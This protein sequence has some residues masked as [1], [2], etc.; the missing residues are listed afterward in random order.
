MRPLS[1]IE[2]EIEQGVAA[3]DA[4]ESARHLLSLGEE[5][6]EHWMAAKGL[7]PTSGK[8][9]GF[10][11]L[12]LHRQSAKGDPSFNACRE[13]CRELVYHYNLVTLEPG[14]PDAA[15]RLVMMRLVAAHIYYFVS[16]KMQTAQLGEFCC[17]SR[18]LR[19]EQ[20][21]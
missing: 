17:S 3:A 19:L 1:T 20:A 8:A 14:H 21:S 12:G 16:G 10:R 9:E 4:A 5:V 11:L 2:S 13:T 7:K 18:D 15:Q 6:L